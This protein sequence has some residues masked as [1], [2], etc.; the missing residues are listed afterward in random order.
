MGV[1]LENGKVPEIDEVLDKADG[2]EMERS[3]MQNDAAKYI[4]WDEGIVYEPH[5]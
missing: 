3:A 2:Y 4:H 1:K 5:S